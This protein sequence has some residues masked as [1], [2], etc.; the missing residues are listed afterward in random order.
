MET[1]KKARELA[2]KILK[3]TESLT[4][5]GESEKEEAEIAA[6]AQMVDEREP[7]ITQLLALK[8]NIDEEMANTDEF[9]AV[10]STIDYIAELDEGHTEYMENVREAV[11]GAIKK[12]KQ[13]Q[14]VHQGYQ[15]LPPDSASR[16]FDTK[17]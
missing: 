7:L 16:R 3:L 6:Y 11:Q 8:Q 12:V 4:L 1:V 9:A 14:R 5:T 17:Q 10:K 13:G 15:A 2:N